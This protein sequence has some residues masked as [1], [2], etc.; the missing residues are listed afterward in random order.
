MVG[1]NFEFLNNVVHLNFYGIYCHLLY[2]IMQCSK[3]VFTKNVSVHEVKSM[4]PIL[5]V[6]AKHKI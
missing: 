2:E 5:I 3:F 1:P 6:L 4:Q